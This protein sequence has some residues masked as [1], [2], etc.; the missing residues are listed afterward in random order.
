[1]SPMANPQEAH[2]ECRVCDLSGI[3]KRVGWEAALAE[4]QTL[5]LA[6]SSESAICAWVH[7]GCVVTSTEEP[8]A[9]HVVYGRNVKF[10]LSFFRQGFMSS[11]LEL[12]LLCSTG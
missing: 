12:E 2:T 7:T 3:S 10:F 1:M 5:G 8:H 4:S 9:D 11:R 6:V